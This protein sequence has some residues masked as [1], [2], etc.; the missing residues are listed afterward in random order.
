MVGTRTSRANVFG[1]LTYRFRPED[2]THVCYHY[3]HGIV[4]FC[5]ATPTAEWHTWV[6][7]Q[8]ET[9]GGWRVSDA[10][11]VAKFELA[12]SI[13]TRDRVG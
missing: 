3:K 8:R 2:E 9:P 12:R 1:E 4:G 5:R 11:E 6:P 10:A 13:A 7:G